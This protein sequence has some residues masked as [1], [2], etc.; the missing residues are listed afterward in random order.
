MQFYDRATIDRVPWPASPEGDYARRVLTALA[1]HGTRRYIA[2][3][4]AEMQVVVTGDAVL[5]VAV[6]DGQIRLPFA[7]YV[8]SPT[9]HYVDYA[10]REMEVEMPG[11]PW[12]RRLASPLLESLRSLLARARAERAVYVNN[13]LLSTNLYPALQAS[14]V[15]DLRDALVRRFPDHLLVFRS[16]NDSLNAD[17]GHDLLGLGF[18]PIF[19]RQVYVLDPGNGEYL[20][21]KS[22]QKDRS[23]AR[24]TPYRWLDADTLTADDAPRLRQLYDD[25][26]LDKYSRYNPQFTDDFFRSALRERWLTFF[27]LERDG[28]LGGVLGFVERHGTMTTP[29]IGYDRA[30]PDEQGL[31]RLLSWKLIDE[32][33]RRGLILHQSSGASAFKRHRGSV[34]SIEYSYVHDAHLPPGRRR[35]WQLLEWLTRRALVPLMRRYGF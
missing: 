3:V 33:Q 25:L 34:A 8:T 16:V 19:S 28:R 4:A 32:A 15:R 12:L 7:S 30:V 22:F 14:H 5:P 20:R 27:A 31:Y 23:L 13:W 1:S 11:R 21:K 6:V 24:R 29:L 2:N 26:Y 9:V 10:L 17:L 35:P 18:R